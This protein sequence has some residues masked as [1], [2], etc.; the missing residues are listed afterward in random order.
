MNM[1][2]VIKRPLV[3]EKAVKAREANNQYAFEVDTRAT[4]Q[5]VRAAVEKLFRVNVLGV[6]TLNQSR[7]GRKSLRG[8]R[9]SKK[10]V[11]FKKAVVTLKKGQKIELFEGV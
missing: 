3:T 5:D 11:C 1:F 6:C 2:D 4:K 8:G 7:P 9:R 10:P